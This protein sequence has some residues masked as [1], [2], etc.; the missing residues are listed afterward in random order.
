MLALQFDRMCV[1]FDID[2]LSNLW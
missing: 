2:Y 1:M